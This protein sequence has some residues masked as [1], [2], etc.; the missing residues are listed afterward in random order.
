[1]G[2]T[3]GRILGS[4]PEGAQVEAVK[5]DKNIISY[6]VSAQ[7]LLVLEQFITAVKD[8]KEKEKAFKSVSLTGPSYTEEFPKYTVTVTAIL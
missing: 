3:S 2:K 8:M 7:S 4:I 6:T 1:L 5:I